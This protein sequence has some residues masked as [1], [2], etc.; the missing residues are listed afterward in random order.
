MNRVAVTALNPL[1]VALVAA[2]LCV[3]APAQLGD[4][5]SPEGKVIRSIDIQF[6]GPD[7]VDENRILAN[8]KLRQGSPF[9]REDQRED[10]INLRERRIVELVDIV[11]EVSGDAVDVKVILMTTG[12]LRAI[13]F[14]GNQRFDNR[15]LS[16]KVKAKIGQPLDEETLLEGKFDVE[17]LYREKGFSDVS[18]TYRTAVEKE[19]G[20]TEVIYSVVEGQ[21]NKLRKILFQ[22]NTAISSKE[23]RKLMTTKQRGIWS[24]ITGKARIDNFVLEDDMAL[25]A[26]DLQ[27]R[28][29]LDARVT[30]QELRR[31][32]EG[33]DQVDLVLHIHEG[34]IYTI[35]EVG[36]EGN[37]AFSDADL[38]SEVKTLSG[39]NYSAERIQKDAQ[40]LED[41]YG[42]QGYADAR[43]T[44]RIASAGDRRVSISHHIREGQI[45]Y[46]RKINLSG[47]EYTRDEV[48]RRELLVEPGQVFNTVKLRQSR[49]ILENTRLFEP[50]SIEVTPEDTSR[51]GYKDINIRVAEGK[52]GQFHAGMA[53]ASVE[54][55]FG[56]VSYSEANFDVARW[57]PFPPRGDGQKLNVSLRYGTRTKDLLLGF[58]EPWFLGQRLAV[59]GEVYWR[60]LLYLSSEYSQRM[61]GGAFWLRRP[62]NDTTR[63]EL[64]YRLQEVEI[65]DLDDNRLID[66]DGDGIRETFIRGVSPEIAAEEG[67]FLESKLTLE[68]LRDTR[69]SNLLPRTGQRLALSGSLSG[70]FL[71][72]DVDTYNL[73]AAFTQH[74]SLPFDTIFTFH[75]EANV[76]DTWANGERVPIFNRHFLG[77]QYD[78]RGFDF[79]EVGPIDEEEEPLGGR[80]SAF[81]RME[82][83]VPVIDRLRMH[84]FLDA[85]FVNEDAYDFGT[86]D[87]N[88]DVGLGVRLDAPFLGPLRLDYGI[89]IEKSE[90]QGSGGRFA[91]SLDYSF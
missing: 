73:S 35:A 57:R 77:G 81:T 84:T 64:E 72:G 67:T 39:Q 9:R 85:G 29:Y 8:M 53:F 10:V 83:S 15:E 79:R 6:L 70:G 18:V 43:V 49:Q 14:Q 89:P 7:V 22:G 4:Q 69:D 26:R 91:F 52:T 44:T 31:V 74:V 45:S 60:E 90:H 58:T 2:L 87:F 11:P 1:V 25:I 65:Y 54:N 17:E 41:Y 20:L 66:R 80:T 86:S 24:W 19:T 33:S 78:L 46:I 82:Y 30:A 48:I 28:G 32:A 42:R 51:P 75:A 55:L 40:R 3:L 27:N 76:A 16:G 88:A 12:T 38:A 21:S 23:L 13:R 71:G 62:V 63:L 47:M 5:N 59:G 36:L 68:L 61:A 34:P 37:S 56:Y 50:G